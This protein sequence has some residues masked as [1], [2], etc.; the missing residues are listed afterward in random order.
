MTCAAL[1]YIH[2]KSNTSVVFAVGAI[3][4][5]TVAI[6]IPLPVVPLVRVAFVALSAI[7]VFGLC[8]TSRSDMPG[9]VTFCA[10]FAFKEALLGAM[11]L[12]KT[13]P[14]FLTFSYIHS[15]YWE[16][17]RFPID[18]LIMLELA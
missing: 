11:I 18:Q 4:L 7:A 5:L 9:F 2:D 8:F 1:T 16:R 15:R 6:S 10:L 3:V 17:R 12:A 14:T 13:S